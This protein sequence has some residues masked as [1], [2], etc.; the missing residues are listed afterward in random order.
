MLQ[1]CIELITAQQKAVGLIGPVFWCG[2]QLKDICKATPG[3]AA[4]VAADLEQPGM[5]I[6]DCEKKIGEHFRK[7]RTSAEEGPKAADKIIREFYGLPAPGGEV[8]PAEQS[9]EPEPE[10]QSRRR[11]VTVNLEDFL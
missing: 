10:K 11:A 7:N 9:G 2:E 1:R 6:A 3:A 5:G 8:V 4:L